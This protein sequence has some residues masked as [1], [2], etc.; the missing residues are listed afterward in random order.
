MLPPGTEPESTEGW[1][2]GAGMSLSELFPHLRVGVLVLAL[3]E[4]PM[5]MWC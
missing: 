3:G 1:P 2:R 5:C 4:K